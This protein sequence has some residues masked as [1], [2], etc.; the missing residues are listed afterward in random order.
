MAISRNTPFSLVEIPAPAAA[1]IAILIPCYNEAAAI[2]GVVREFRAALPTATIHVYDNNSSD[3]TVTVARAAGAVIGRETLQ[4]KGHVV[5]RMFADIEADI[6]ILADGDGTYD[7]ASAP[8][9]VAAM[10]AERLDMVNG[11]REGAAAAA[12]RRGHRVGNFVLSRLIG[13]VFGNRVRDSLS[14]Y[15]VFSRRFVKSFPA[16]ASGFDVEPELIVHA[17]ELGMP[18]RE[19]ATPYRAR[20]RGSESKLRTVRD[21]IRVL[22]TIAVLIKEER[23]LPFFGWIFLLLTAISLLLAAPI[24]ATYSETGLVPRFPT[25]ILATGIMLLAFLSLACGLILDTVTRG[26]REMKHMQ[27][28]SIPALAAVEPDGED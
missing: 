3:E 27:Y 26:R 11:R 2:G 8:A 23:P 18:V 6:Y 15:K 22:S 12:Y 9:L 25:A 28:L 14:G 7:A 10:A 19:I 1:R 21:G 5:R 16:H 24:V 17:L 4:G 13:H 20:P